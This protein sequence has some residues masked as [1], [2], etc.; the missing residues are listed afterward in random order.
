VTFALEL[1]GCRA[2]VTAGTKG[3]GA[4]VVDVLRENGARVMTTARSIPQDARLDVQYLAANLT[5]S[6]DFR[7]TSSLYG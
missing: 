1:A 5:L 3:V 2:L 6:G 4:A 7:V